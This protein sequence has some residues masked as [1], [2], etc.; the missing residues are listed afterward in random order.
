MLALDRGEREDF[1]KVS[2]Q[3]NAARAVD[4]ICHAVVTADNACADA[5]REAAQDAYDRLIHPS[6]EREIRA[7]L[8][9]RA[10]EGAIKV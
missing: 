4:V 10:A 3:P 5:V 7:D 8:T 9:A 2:V 6:L 1:L